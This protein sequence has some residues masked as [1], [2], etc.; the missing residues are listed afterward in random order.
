MK[1]LLFI[2]SLLML[3]TT[4]CTAQG[5]EKRKSPHE[6]VSNDQVSVTY[7]RP[8]KKDRAIFGSLVKY[9]EVWRTGADE[10]TE[11]TFKKDGTIGG[12]PVKAGTY[13]LFT[14]PG[15]KEW[16][17]ILNGKTGQWGA[18]D[19]EKNKGQDVLKVNVPSSTSSAAAEQLTITLPANALVIAW[20]KTQVSVP[21][22]F[23]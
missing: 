10:A 23:K 5:N 22:G 21:L 2:A 16:T 6:T 19:Y 3:V 13:T 18:Y 14:I 20:D 1:N 4:S 9:G 11:I 12:Q 7:G 17:I 8:Y 15:E